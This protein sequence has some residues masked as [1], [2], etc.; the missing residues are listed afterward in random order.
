MGA[1]NCCF[2]EDRKSNTY[3]AYISN[4]QLTGIYGLGDLD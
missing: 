2:M 4:A 1:T 3:K